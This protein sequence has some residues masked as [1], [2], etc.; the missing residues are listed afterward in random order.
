MGNDSCISFLLRHKKC[1]INVLTE[2]S[3]NSLTIAVAHNNLSTAYLLLGHKL[4]CKVQDTALLYAAMNENGEELI[5]LLLNHGA[6]VNGTDDIGNT[7]LMYACA[8]SHEN[9]VNVLIS[10]E[11]KPSIEINKQN[12]FGWT[13]LHMLTL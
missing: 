10:R 7:A 3:I 12:K 6:N 9:I 8:R 11:W 13:S 2:T 4:K 5:R 1:E